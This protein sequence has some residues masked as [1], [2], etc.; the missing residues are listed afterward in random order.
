MT[1]QSNKAFTLIET[2]VVLAVVAIVASL[3]YASY[4]ESLRKSARGDAQAALAGLASTMQ[5]HYT[6]Q[7]PSTFAGAAAGGAD[8][9]AP[10]I[11]ATQSPIDGA[12]K[13]YNLRIQS[14]NATSFEL[15]A[16]PI[17]GTDQA[18]DK[19]GTFTLA[20]TGVRGIT[21]ANTGVTWQDCWR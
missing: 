17:S 3:A 16:I 8:T 9:G 14:A 12:V 2:M 11:F 18:N 15:R 21:G 6:E 20:S 19:C 13:K 7:T 10:A 5:R 4:A 1:K